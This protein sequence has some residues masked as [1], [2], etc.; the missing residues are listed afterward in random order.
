MK[1]ETI[2]IYGDKRITTH[3]G[4]GIDVASQRADDLDMMAVE[5]IRSIASSRSVLA[6]DVGC[7]HGGQTVRMAKAGAHVI[8]MDAN[9][10]ST[11]IAEMVGSEGLP[12]G[13][14][15]FLQ[16]GVESEPN[17][18]QV[19]VVMCQRMIHYL[20]QHAAAKALSWFWRIS[21][22]GGRMFLSASGLDSELGNGYPAKDVLVES[23]FA[24]LSPEMSEKHAIRSPVCLYR[25]DELAEMA[26]KA[27]W[28]VEK[29]FVSPFGN[30][31][32]VAVKK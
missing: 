9:D 2:N 30:V 16:S 12:D 3:A 19:D 31:K 27:G 29:V 8:A 11:E 28:E 5:Y 26:K 24:H 18:G 15:A 17:V 14:V 20:E 4:K 21:V 7:G 32:L 6:V 13:C 1:Q 23:R 10:Y 22:S 25:P